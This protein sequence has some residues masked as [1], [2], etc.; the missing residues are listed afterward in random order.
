MEVRMKKKLFEKSAGIFFAFI[1]ISNFSW[2]TSAYIDKAFAGEFV[3]SYT[4]AFHRGQE[5]EPIEQ[6]PI[7]GGT[8]ELD[9]SDNDS[10]I[11]FDD[12]AKFDATCP[13]LPLEDFENTNAPPDSV[14]VCSTSINSATNDACYSPGAL[15]DGFTL[16][17]IPVAG[18]GEFVV[19]TPPFIGVTSV[20]AGP[21]NFDDDSEISF[22]N[23]NV[24]GV[25][26]DLLSGVTAPG[27]TVD[28]EIFGV[29]DVSLG[30]TKIPLLNPPGQ[31]WGVRVDQP[32]TRIVFSVGPGE[33]VD[34]LVFGDC[35]I[36]CNGKE[37]TILGTEGHDILIGTDGPDVIHGLGGFDWIRGLGGD[38]VICG[39]DGSDVIGAGA[40]NDVVLGESGHDAI[41][42]GP[43]NDTLEGGDGN[44]SIFGGPGN[45]EV[46]GNFG[47]DSLYGKDGDDTLFGGWGPDNGTI[48]NNDTCYDVR[49]THNWGCEVF[50]E[51]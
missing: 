22:A 45:D 6:T 41:W 2:G 27:D 34:N 46:W 35:G 49:W 51:Q 21:N 25:G 38:D 42:G 12:R 17:G 15:I 3:E 4:E 33:L 5:S 32:V 40:G 37:P 14:V 13:G 44:D 23:K 29:G 1:L 8:F 18:S 36:H 16:T 11:F 9:V 20:V 26:V 19:L 7:Q 24:T 30:K 39:G 31:F 48:D 47:N 10:L 43:G 50:Y 28:I